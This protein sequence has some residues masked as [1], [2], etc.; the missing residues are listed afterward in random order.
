LQPIKLIQEY[1]IFRRSELPCSSGP[2]V[3]HFTVTNQLASMVIVGNVILRFPIGNLRNIEQV[4]IKPREGERIHR[5]FQDPLAQHLIVCLESR[6][7]MYIGRSRPGKR[8]IPRLLTK[9]KGHLIESVAWNKVEQTEYTT[10]PILLGTSNGIILETDIDFQDSLL[11]KKKA[12]L[13]EVHRL[14]YDLAEHS[15]AVTGLHME[16]FPQQTS[17]SE[18]KYYILA[19]TPKRIYQFIGNVAKGETPQFVQLFA[20]YNPGTVQFLEIPGTLR[21]SQLQLWPAKPN[22]IP[23][24]FAWLTGAGIYYG[25]L[26]FGD[27]MPGESLF[28]EKTLIPYSQSTASASPIGMALTQFHCVLLYRD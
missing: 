19:T 26:G 27:H 20:A 23:L 8:A 14:M 7:C 4:E 5:I 17:S 1:P 11:P 9:V 3:T 18:I 10:G 12:Y 28:I 16:P 15:E 13:Q 21:E 24:S 6:D 22:T 2:G 25:Q